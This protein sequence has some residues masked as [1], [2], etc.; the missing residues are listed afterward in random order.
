MAG[1]DKKKKDSSKINIVNRRAEYE[2]HFLD[3]MEAGIELTG[4]EIKS[5][6]KGSAD[7]RDAYCFFKKG[8]LYV[9]N[10]YIAEYDWGNQ[11]NHEPRRLRKLLLRGAELRKME[12]KIKERGFTIVPYRVY[13]NERG[14]A[15]LEIALAQGKKTHDKRESIKEKDV[16]R[17]LDR[18]KKTRL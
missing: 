14:F 17:D 3:R 15:K 7:L 5:V 13:L 11:F 6:R 18:I 9:K 12:K 10:L 4:T 2:F 1:T 16:K 8:E